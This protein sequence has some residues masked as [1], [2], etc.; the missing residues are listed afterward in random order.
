[1]KIGFSDIEGIYMG[2]NIQDD[3]HM[4]HSITYAVAK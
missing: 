4:N 3:Q 2:K 1:M